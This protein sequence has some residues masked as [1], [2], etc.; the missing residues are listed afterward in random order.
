MVRRLVINIQPTVKPFYPI[1]QMQ[2]LHINMTGCLN[3][4]ALLMRGNVHVI[5][6]FRVSMWAMHARWA[7]CSLLHVPCTGCHCCITSDFGLSSS[8]PE[9]HA[10]RYAEDNFPSHVC[11]L[12]RR[13]T[14]R[15]KPRDTESNLTQSCWACAPHVFQFIKMSSNIAIRHACCSSQ[16]GAVPST[17]REE[18]PL[19]TVTVKMTLGNSATVRLH[20]NFPVNEMS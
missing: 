16:L 10:S 19:K 7:I 1:L 3:W 14:S 5:C 20:A 2:R 15:M 9:S 11:R 8:E 13:I 12:L 4:K 6:N 17:R 18:A